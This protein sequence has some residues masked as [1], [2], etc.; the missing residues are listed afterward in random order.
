MQNL[1]SYPLVAEDI[2]SSEKRYRL[3]AGKEQLEYLA[4]VLKVPEVKAFEA[5]IYTK[6][7]KKEH[8]LDVWGDVKA[9]LR[10]QSVISLEYFDKKYANSFA[11]AYDTKATLKEQK[12]LDFDF[13][14]EIPDVIVDGKIDLVDIAIEQLAL[15]L[16]DNPRREGEI[17]N[18][19]SEFSEEDDK[20]LNPFSVLEKLKK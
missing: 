5:E 19:K 8:L 2:S 3:K 9:E 15:V 13:D 10:L 4:E 16:E 11:V 6:L 18:Y 20:A 1:F 7:K 12:E 14:D 17:F